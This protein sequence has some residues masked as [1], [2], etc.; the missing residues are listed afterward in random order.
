M[1]P[2]QCSNSSPAIS[3]LLLGK[4]CRA[5]RYCLLAIPIS[6]HAVLYTPAAEGFFCFEPVANLTNA[7]N[8]DDGDIP[9]IAPGESFSAWIG[10]RA[11]DT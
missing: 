11:I 7:L 8:R 4:G 3:T 6:P 1:R 2:V 5:S 9:I 10:F